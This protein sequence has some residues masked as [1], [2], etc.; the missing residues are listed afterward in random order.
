MSELDELQIKIEELRAKMIKI[1]SR[2]KSLHAPDVVAASQEMDAVL[3]RYTKLKMD[4]DNTE[5]K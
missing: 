1:K 3:N 2:R 4:A 5:D